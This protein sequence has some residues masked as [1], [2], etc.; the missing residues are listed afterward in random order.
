MCSWPSLWSSLRSAS[1][2]S[3][4]RW[5]EGSHLDGLACLC[6]SGSVL[7]QGRSSSPSASRTHSL[8]CVLCSAGRGTPM[9]RGVPTSSAGTAATIRATTETMPGR[10]RRASQE[11]IGSRTAGR[12]FKG[13][14]PQVRGPSRLLPQVPV[15]RGGDRSL[16]SRTNLRVGVECVAQCSGAWTTRTHLHPPGALHGLVTGTRARDRLRWPGSFGIVLPRAMPWII[17]RRD[18]CA[19]ALNDGQDDRRR[20]AGK[21]RPTDPRPRL[22]RV[23]LDVYGHLF[24]DDLGDLAQA[25]EPMSRRTGAVPAIK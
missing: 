17:R 15:R 6:A 23:H 7:S 22:Y 20:P 2:C 3:S 5:C 16:S 9:T 14:R 18:A 13:I 11:E 1:C 21:G 12:A 4:S 10:G 25:L 24:D 8:R 19:S